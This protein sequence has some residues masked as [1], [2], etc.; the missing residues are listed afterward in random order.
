VIL[1]R[2]YFYTKFMMQLLKNTGV[3]FSKVLPGA[4]SVAYVKSGGFIRSVFSKENLRKIINQFTDPNQTDEFKALSA[5]VGIFIGI[6]PVWGLQTVI[7]IFTAMLFKLNKP[8]VLV[9][10]QISFPPFLPFVVLLSYQAGS[11]WMPADT[12]QIAFNL[13]APFQNMSS[14]LEQY[15]YGSFTLA[16]IA[17][18]LTGAI[19]LTVLKLLKAFKA[20]RLPVLQKEI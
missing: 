8:L 19:T 14:H 7:A 16:I 9:F 12:R 15:L 2:W 13:S 3:F 18:L 11:F 4:I 1:L 6:I 10:S 5:A 17:A 20:Y